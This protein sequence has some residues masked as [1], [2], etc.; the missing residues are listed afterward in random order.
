MEKISLQI[1]LTKV[2]FRIDKNKLNRPITPMEIEED[3]KGL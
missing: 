2:K 3:N 1:P